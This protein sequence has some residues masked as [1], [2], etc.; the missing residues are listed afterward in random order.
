V[1]LI[2]VAEAARMGRA[3]LASRI[4]KREPAYFQS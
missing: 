2:T 3:P 4:R 1:L